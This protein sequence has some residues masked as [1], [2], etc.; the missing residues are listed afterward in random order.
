MRTARFL[1][2]ALVLALA[3]CPGRSGSSR[4]GET[5]LRVLA[6]A[7]L[8][9]P[10]R[11]IAT[12][13]EEKNPGVRVQVSAGS[14]SQLERQLESGAACDVFVAA[15]PG[16]VDRLVA[17]GLLD[18]ETRASVA[19]NALVAI[20]PRG[21]ALPR[22]L[23]ALASHKRVAVGSRGVPVGDYAREAIERSGLSERLSPL[24]ASY[25][26]EPSVVTAVAEGGAPAGI[27]YAS[28]TVAHPRRSAI[29][30]A[31]EID[32]ALT[33][34]IVYPAAVARSSPHPGLSRALVEFLRGEEARAVLRR[35]GFAVSR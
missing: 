14:S 5:T 17:K 29:E 2:A 35:A 27:V 30:R 20:V 16:P 26:D 34:R 32:P 3:G 23:A 33:S 12:A 15:A 21:D 7:S 11:E 13:F 6:A 4:E 8:A 31:F 22:D 18:G 24:L 1:G 19:S 10:L 25:P 9:G 28:S